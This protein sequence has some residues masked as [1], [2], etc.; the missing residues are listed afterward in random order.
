MNLNL[1]NL[2]I[3][4]I[5]II[6]ILI[7][8]LGIGIFVN[9]KI[10]K[11]KIDINLKNLYFLQGLIFI[12]FLFILINFFIPISDSISA[13]TILI[14]SILYFFYFFNLRSKKQELIFI[15]SVSL[16]AFFYSFYAGLNDDFIYHYET[17]KNYKN[18][19]LFE[20][21]H[22]RM[23]SYNSHWLFLNS[24]FSFSSYTTSLFVLSSLL[25]SISIYDFYSAFKKYLKKNYYFTS[26]I[27]YFFLIFFI[28]VLD[29]YKDLGT[30]VPGLIVSIYV[31][32]IIT[33]YIFDKKIKESSNIF[34]IILSLSLFA[35]QIKIT[36][37]LIILFVIFL[38]FR[39]NLSKINYFLFLFICLIPLPWIFQNF[40]IS[41]CLVWPIVLTCFANTDLA[42]REIYLIESFAKGDINVSIELNGLNWVKVW[43]TNHFYKILEIYFVYILLLIAP[44]FYILLSKTYKKTNFINSIKD[45]YF[46]SN[47]IIIFLIIYISNII[48]FLNAPA[49]RFGIF[50]NLC[51]IIF[52][53]L[54]LWLYMLEK[55]FNNLHKYS[56][57]ILYLV[58]IFFIYENISKINWYVKRYDTWPPINKEQLLDRKKF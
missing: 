44:F 43:F 28:G 22:H 9:D 4:P 51:L 7:S 27:C 40:I 34:L 38:I 14:G 24:I 47:Y 31:I 3:F 36:N 12:G 45:I 10:I 53:I 52:L 23:H 35:V 21:M 20:I 26:T 41:N 25:F 17:I 11:N 46:N 32:I 19:N 16:M 56:K 49:Y 55:F 39:L 1:L 42:I 6:F 58:F 50:Y 48:W 57:I 30:D 29:K 37:S 54:P 15:I 5:L 13:L 18:K 2:F 8:I 33:Y